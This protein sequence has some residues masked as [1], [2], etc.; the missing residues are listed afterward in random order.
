MLNAYLYRV[1]KSLLKSPLKI[2]LGILGIALCV[3][4]ICIPMMDGYEELPV[5]SNQVKL[6][7]I[8]ILMCAMFAFLYFTGLS[9]GVATFSFS[10]VNFH[11]AGPFTEKFNLLIAATGSFQVAGLF[12]FVLCCQSAVLYSAFGLYGAGFVVFLIVSFFV[13]LLGYSC[14]TIVGTLTAGN[15]KLDKIVDY[16]S[17]AVVAVLVLG[18]VL[19]AV[20]NHGSFEALTE[21][22]MRAL[23][24]ELGTSKWLQIFPGG[25]WINMIYSG[26]IL[27]DKIFILIGSLLTI[28]LIALLVMVYTKYDF[29]YYEIAIE[30][31]QKIADVKEA[32]RAGVDMDN[33]NINKKVKVGKETIT[34]GWGA[35]AFTQRFFLENARA[36]KI[37]FANK[38]TLLYRLICF[39]YLFFM[40]NVEVNEDGTMPALIAGLMMII[41]LDLPLYAGG[42]TILEFN[43]PYIF[44]VPEKSSKKLAA[45]ILGGL[46]EMLFDAILCTAI[47]GYHVQPGILALVGCFAM[48]LIFAFICQ[49]GALICL[50]IFKSLGKYMLMI[51]RYFVVIFMMLLALIPGLIIGIAFLGGTTAAITLCSAGFGLI[52]CLILLAVSRNLID[53]VEFG[54]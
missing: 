19:E 38:L 48:F 51:F 26:I 30:N 17:Y 4:M 2:I 52:L 6:G 54:S 49:L 9:S 22:G 13:M 50:R 31:A 46:P 7:G 35:S 27:G 5:I 21:N 32:R 1:R 23:I 10:D 39:I 14:G 25:G 28:G 33:A 24:G 40:S 34:K 37:F 45:C 8:N 15:E 12:M 3:L 29:D 42:K 16:G 44:L 43:R 18:A 20:K 53:K 36:T 41:I 47:I 11:M